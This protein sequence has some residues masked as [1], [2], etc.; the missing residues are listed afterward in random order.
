LHL[1]HTIEV[2]N[3]RDLITIHTVLEHSPE[4][5]DAVR[6]LIVSRVDIEHVLATALGRVPNLETLNIERAS[7]NI[8]A[9]W[10]PKLARLC[11]R[12]RSLRTMGFRFTCPPDIRLLFVSG[13]LE[14]VHLG[15]V[16][17][18][19]PVE[20]A[21]YKHVDE[22]SHISPLHDIMMGLVRNLAGSR[23]GYDL[24]FDMCTRR[25]GVWVSLRI[26]SIESSEIPERYHFTFDERT[27]ADDAR[28]QCRSCLVQLPLALTAKR[29][30][31]P[32]VF[33]S[34]AAAAIYTS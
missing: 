22:R 29:I 30:Q 33:P 5:V 17:S 24:D 34:T 6:E 16:G 8:P 20:R 32:R 13:R 26:V 9:A 1:F 23:A 12:L 21:V 18:D 7:G 19:G 11:E 31:S 14:N 25:H 27:T 3:F 10:K 2:K 4:L 28:G 15:D